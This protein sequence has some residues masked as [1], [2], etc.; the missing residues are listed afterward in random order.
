MLD[1]N[2]LL[3]MRMNK[4]T[5]TNIEVGH[6]HVRPS[7]YIKFLPFLLLLLLI[8]LLILINS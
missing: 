3:S 8:L 1:L 6:E 7:V 5:Y 4:Y 2:K